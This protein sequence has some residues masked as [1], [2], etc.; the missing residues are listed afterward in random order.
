PLR[1]S[2]ALIERATVLVTNDSA[3]LHLA[4]AVG[5]PVV[6]LFGPTVPAFGFG[7]TGAAD[8][9]VEVSG[10]ACRPCST[11][12][13]MVCPLGHHRCMIDLPVRSVLAAFDSRF[14]TTD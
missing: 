6:A 8:R 10:L 4:G 12:G 3:P 11:H 14:V 9:V 2:A 1:A 7:P 5:T 13:P